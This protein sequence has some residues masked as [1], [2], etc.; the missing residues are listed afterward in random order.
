MM[1]KI[2][3]ILLLVSIM[4]G[5]L[6]AQL[7][8]GIDGY[9]GGGLS[10]P[11]KDLN[12][13]W[14]TGQ[15]GMLGIGYNLTPGLDAVAFYAYRTFPASPPADTTGIIAPANITEDFKIHEYGLDLRANLAMTGMKFRPYGLV[16]AGMAKMPKETKMFYSVG[17]GIKTGLMPKV[18]LF[19]EARYTHVSV[20]DFDISYVPVMAGL[21]LS[22]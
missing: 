19:L 3:L 14:K 12:A 11:A 6:S 21:N 15:H 1:K 10:F 7:K 13:N 22:L 9:A 4:A 18:Y 2:I 8:I 5:P 17:G 20:D 16:S